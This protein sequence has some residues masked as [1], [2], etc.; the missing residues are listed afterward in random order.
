MLISK[1]KIVFKHI[2]AERQLE[3]KVV[4]LDKNKHGISKISLINNYLINLKENGL[5]MNDL[6]ARYFSIL[7]GWSSS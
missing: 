6:R 5:N 3:K 7:D 1:R 2:L 4:E